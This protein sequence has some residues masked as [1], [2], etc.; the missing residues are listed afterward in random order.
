MALFRWDK[1]WVVKGEGCAGSDTRAVKIVSR[2]CAW[3]P[4]K[5][6]WKEGSLAFSVLVCQLSAGMCEE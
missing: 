2:R 5:S 3:L 4:D 6:Y 1:G